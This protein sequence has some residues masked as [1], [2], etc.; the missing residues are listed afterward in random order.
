MSQL[1]DEISR[2]VGIKVLHAA[3]QTISLA[4]SKEFSILPNRKAAL[5]K[6]IDDMESEMGRLSKSLRE[7]RAGILHLGIE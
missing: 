1:S 6:R 2:T 7:I 4:N 5:L 3:P